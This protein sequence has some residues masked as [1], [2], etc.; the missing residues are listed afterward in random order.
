MLLAVAGYRW[1]DKL[2]DRREQV[3]AVRE[4]LPSLA[5]VVHVPYAGG[6]DDVLPD[7]VRV[8]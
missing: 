7:T 6:A 8:E 2:V 3:A 4:Q 1:G 5:T